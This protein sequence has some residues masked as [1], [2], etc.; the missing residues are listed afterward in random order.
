MKPSGA[1]NRF[2]QL[3]A[4]LERQLETYHT[5]RR[6]SNLSKPLAKEAK[7]IMDMIVSG[8]ITDP[9]KPLSPSLGEE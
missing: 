3:N 6:L 8:I 2:R 5:P 4:H 7:R 1:I 9:D